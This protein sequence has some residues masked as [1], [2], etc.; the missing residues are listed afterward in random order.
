MLFRSSGNDYSR[1][2]VTGG[3]KQMMED[4]WSSVGMRMNEA[5]SKVGQQVTQKKDQANVRA[6]EAA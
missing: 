6:K 3:A 5:I 1:F 2:I 4:T